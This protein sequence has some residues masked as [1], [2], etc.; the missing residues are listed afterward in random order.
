MTKVLLTG[1]FTL[2]RAPYLVR[3]LGVMFVYDD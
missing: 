2:S 3:G 1:E